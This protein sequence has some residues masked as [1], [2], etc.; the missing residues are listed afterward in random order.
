MLKKR[1]SANNYHHVREAVVDNIASVIHLSTK[2]NLADMSSTSLDGRK[3]QHL[4]K[5]QVFPPAEKIGKC[6]PDMQACSV[7]MS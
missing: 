2:Y 1:H 6:E 5:N 3:H 7:M 4:L